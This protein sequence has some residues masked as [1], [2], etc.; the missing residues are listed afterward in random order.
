MENE[1]EQKLSEFMNLPVDGTWT[2]DDI[3]KEYLL[4]KDKKTVSKIY[5]IP[6]REVSDVVRKYSRIQQR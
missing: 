1:K 3:Y 2:D 5:R 4:C 6:L